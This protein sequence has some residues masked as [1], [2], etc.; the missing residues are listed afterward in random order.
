MPP[1]TE[2]VKGRDQ[3]FWTN[4][5]PL[6]TMSSPHCPNGPRESVTS[7]S[8]C[9]RLACNC[10]TAEQLTPP[11]SRDA[12]CSDLRGSGDRRHRLHRRRGPREQRCP[13][14]CRC[15]SPR[16]QRPVQAPPIEWRPGRR[17]RVARGPTRTSVDR[18]CDAVHR[19]WHGMSGCACMNGRPSTARAGHRARR[20]QR[21]VRAR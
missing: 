16:Q 5:G 15:P 14:R 10:D 2:R 9:L 17:Q 1:I 7:T 12:G 18:R 4:R 6:R 13:L 8:S 11:P 20:R 3:Y 21:A 19:G